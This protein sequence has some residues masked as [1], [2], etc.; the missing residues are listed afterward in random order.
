MQQEAILH[1]ISTLLSRFQEE[2][3]IVNANGEFSIN[4]HAEN[5]LLKILNVAYDLDL[6]NVNYEEGKTFAAIDLRDEARKVAVQVTSSGTVD[7]V[8]HTLEEC[9]KNGYDVSYEHLYFYFLKGMD[10]NVK[11][12]YP[13]IKKNFGRFWPECV[14]F[15]DHA[16]FYQELNRIN[17]FGKCRQIKDLLEEQF[18]DTYSAEERV[19][20]S[21]GAF[22]SVHPDR[23]FG[24][25]EKIEKVLRNIGKE[26]VI[27]VSGEGGIGKTEFCR[28]VLSRAEESGM[29]YTAVSLIECRTFDDMIKR[30]AG[31]YGI[32]VSSTDEADQIERTVLEKAEGILYLD[33]FEDM[34][35][36]KNTAPDQ[37]RL[38]ISFLRKCRNNQ[39]LTA[40]ISSRYKLDVD[41]HLVEEELDVLDEESA[42]RLFN[43]LWTGNDTLTEN[44]E[45]REFVVNDLYRYP[46][47]I[48]LAAR[49]KRYGISIGELR[50]KWRTN[51]AKVKVKWPDNKR[52][53]SLDTA[54]YM[55]YMEIKDMES[56]RAMWELFTLFPDQIEKGVVEE[57]VD[58]CDDALITLM[59]LGVIH[60]NGMY[61]SVQPTL[62]DY[63]KETDEYVG[64]I[65]TII[66]KLVDHY[67][68]IYGEDGVRHWG[69][70]EDLHAS[71]RLPDALFLMN[72]LVEE[73]E[74]DNIGR[75]HRCIRKY[76]QD[77]PYE[78]I[79][80]VEAAVDLLGHKEDYI[81][82]NLL[83][84]CGG[85]EMRTN[86][87]KEAEDHYKESEELYRRIQRDLR[88][89]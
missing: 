56:A 40:L 65:P 12:D 80:P 30:I 23:F 61:L 74:I 50:E 33:N 19:I 11:I 60:I 71:Q 66:V 86:K 6:R 38:A 25:E 77:A 14:H 84:Y 39:N 87:L 35:S 67:R 81:T 24:R 75:L 1:R 57:L 7:K 15:L 10:K 59:D 45:I 5:V 72:R 63:I 88:R 85:L 52:H 46:L 49:Q 62:R 17:D 51:W 48:V 78:A 73:H 20:P 4:I 79:I 55:T 64:D 34:I 3:K 70:E 53:Q 22:V 8:V 21:Q 32:A 83:E 18:A 54:L 2:V 69:S 28:E 68:G 44:E 76:Y 47:S 13:R 82:A 36:G 31:Q 41:F 89:H 43:W 42:V 9:A 27:L 29:S 26:K 16:G 58:G 37:Q